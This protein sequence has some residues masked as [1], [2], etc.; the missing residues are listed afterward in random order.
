MLV[1]ESGY[2][3]SPN[4]QLTAVR[5]RVF[6][7]FFG[8]AVLLYQLSVRIDLEARLF[9]VRSYDDLVI[10]SA[11]RIVFP[12][13]LNDLTSGCVLI[14]CLLNRSREG[15][16]VYLFSG[17]FRAL[18][19]RAQSEADADHCCQHCSRR[20]HIY[21]FVPPASEGRAKIFLA[22]HYDFVM[23]LA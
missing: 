2:K 9:P 14:N 1:E 5:L 4:V 3:R 7:L 6:G 16:H 17:L 18:R 10:P 21:P 8:L 11:I 23:I 13:D 19:G 22:S 15:L 20:F 12:F